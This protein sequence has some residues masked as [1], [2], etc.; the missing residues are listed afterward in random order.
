[1]EYIFFYSSVVAMI[2]LFLFYLSTRR[3]K[4]PYI[5][6]GITTVGFSL[7]NDILLGDYFN[8]FY[9]ISPQKS[10]LYIV[11]AAVF[12]YPIV[13]I[14]YTMFLP[15]T[16]KYTLVYT[17]FWIIG[18]LIFEYF[19]VLSKAIVFTGWRP[20]PWSIVLYIIAYLWIYYF[21]KYLIKKTI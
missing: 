21:Y 13:N 16:S 12:I 20:I 5:I 1:M 10:N 8:L 3:L 2:I 19:S 9:Y 7:I 18:M 14:A 11:L 4:L 17:I 6:I 15:K